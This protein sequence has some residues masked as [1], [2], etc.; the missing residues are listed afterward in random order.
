[1]SEQGNFIIL[2]LNKSSSA[3]NGHRRILEIPLFNNINFLIPVINHTFKG[4]PPFKMAAKQI[5]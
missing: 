2:Y 1:M 4:E 3:V 5:R